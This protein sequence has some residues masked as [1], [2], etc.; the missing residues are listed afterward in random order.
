M[1]ERIKN[2]L[3]QQFSA[4]GSSKPADLRNSGAHRIPP[5][6]NP[7]IPVPRSDRK[8]VDLDPQLSGT[9]ENAESGNNVLIR[10]RY[11]REDSGTHETLKIIDDSLIDTGEKT[12]IDPYNTGEFD[13]SKNWGNRFRN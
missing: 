10:N 8:P 11:V 2:W 1:M 12:G 13:R 6:L 5:P 3:K 4:A 7:P 9:I